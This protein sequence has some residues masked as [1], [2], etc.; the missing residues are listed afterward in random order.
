MAEYGEEVDTVLV[1]VR[2]FDA[3]L[4]VFNT[5]TS[6][7]KAG[8]FSAILTAFIVEVYKGLQEDPAETSAQILR[9]ITMQLENNTQSLPSIPSKT[10]TTS[11]TIVAINALWFSS[12]IFSLFAALLAILVKQWLHVYSKWPDRE[13]PKDTIILRRMYREGFFQWHVP[14]IIGLL[15]VLLQF[16]LLLFVIGLTMYMWTL[17]LVI[18]GILTVLVT[19]MIVATIVTIALPFFSDNCPYKSPIGLVVASLKATYFNPPEAP[20]LSSWQRRDITQAKHRLAVD[21]VV[22][23]ADLILD[24]SSRSDLES[25]LNNP[26]D[27]DSLLGSRISGLPDGMLRLLSELI[28]TATKEKRGDQVDT[29]WETHAV[30]LLVFMTR[31]TRGDGLQ[32]VAEAFVNILKTNGGHHTTNYSAI[33]SSLRHVI[34]EE[35]QCA[36]C[37]SLSLTRS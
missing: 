10:H 23:Q 24:I 6:T 37:Y 4:I 5:L 35:L 21:D 7:L 18:A 30:S 8:L 34:R 14:E 17:H 2:T 28:L 3:I 15:P 32:N 19:L 20:T 16:A 12:L 26:I 22:A 33:W 29:Q 13:P 36:Y 11:S 9:R 27:A 31:V 1:F 25:G